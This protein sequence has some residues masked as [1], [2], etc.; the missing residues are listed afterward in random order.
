M[1]VLNKS[2]QHYTILCFYISFCKLCSYKAIQLFYCQTWY[3]RFSGS[4]FPS[5]SEAKCPC[6]WRHS[7]CSFLHF[8][9]CVT[10][11]KYP[12]K[13]GISPAY[14]SEVKTQ[15][16]LAALTEKQQSPLT[17]GGCIAVIRPTPRAIEPSMAKCLQ[18]TITK[19]GDSSLQVNHRYQLGSAR[20]RYCLNTFRNG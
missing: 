16:W 15:L 7:P 5:D 1:D 6:S 3:I 8:S 17:T 4:H 13:V 2:V 12:W 18:P 20:A 19:H 10:L 9:L 11:G 14:W